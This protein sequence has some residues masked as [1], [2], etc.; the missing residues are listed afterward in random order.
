MPFYRATARHT[1]TSRLIY[2]VEVERAPEAEMRAAALQKAEKGEVFSE[3]FLDLL[4]MQ[5]Q[6]D[7]ATVGEVDTLDLDGPPDAPGE[8]PSGLPD[9]VRFEVD[10]EVTEVCEYLHSLPADDLEDAKKTFS[11][12]LFGQDCFQR[13]IEVPHRKVFEDT[14][15]MARE[16][17]SAQ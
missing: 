1:D 15:R 7:L 6:V 2:T 3:E 5:R 13:I 8:F 11:L 12:A 4:D 10:V 9:P 14:L 17:S 16:T